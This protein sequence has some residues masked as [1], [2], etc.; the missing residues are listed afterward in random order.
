MLRPLMLAV[1]LAC[2]AVL[3]GQSKPADPKHP[4]TI[5]V[6]SRFPKAESAD[7]VASGLVDAGYALDRVDGTTITPAPITLKNVTEVHLR[8][9]LLG[10]GDST[11]VV[12]SAT[13]DMVYVG[14]KGGHAEANRSGWKKLTRG[15]GRSWA[16][17]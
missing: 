17:P 8:V 10:S 2:P 15:R 4:R 14:L 16:M 7:R 13:Y 1:A 9:N 3:A 11:R 6:S 12:L 5:E